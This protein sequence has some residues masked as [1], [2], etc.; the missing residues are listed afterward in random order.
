MPHVWRFASRL[1]IGASA[2]VL[3]AA[4]P[5]PSHAEGE[6]D[7]FRAKLEKWV[8]TRQLIS[9]EESEWEAEEETLRATRDLLREQKKDLQ[10]AGAEVEE[11][12][13]EAD[14]ERRELLLRRGEFQRANRAVEDEIRRLEEEVLAL[15]P[16]LPQ[17]LQER[18]EP[19]LVQ[20][21]DDPEGTEQ[22]LGQRLVNVLGALSQTDK[23]NGTANLVGETRA[24]GGSEQKVQIRT[25]YWGLGQGIY[26][27]AQGRTAGVARPGPDGWEF[28]DDDSLTDD[29]EQLLDIYEGNIDAIEF[30]ELPVEIR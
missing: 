19:L 5:R 7:G 23:W 1:V 10:A 14:E 12:A 17:P 20:I 29:A 30:V 6:V 4:A 21:P 3:L 13:T 8:E 18:L 11:A 16:R 26:V 27:A 2:L 24:V 22:P 25:L 28:L 9:E 15:A